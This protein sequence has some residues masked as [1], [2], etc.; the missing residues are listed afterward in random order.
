MSRKLSVFGISISK[1][2]TMSKHHVKI[3][4]W[5][6]G[7]LEELKQTVESLEEAL[8]IIQHHHN[9]RT[10]EVT[11]LVAKI[12]NEQGELIHSSE[13]GPADSYA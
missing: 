7:A 6:N 5:T 10:G 8:G 12:Y 2:K 4:K 1:D 13:G 9:N 11:S 3:H